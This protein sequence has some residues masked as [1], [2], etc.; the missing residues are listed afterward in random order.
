MPTGVINATSVN[1]R[2]PDGSIVT[3]LPEGTTVDIQLDDASTGQLLVT[4]VIAGQTR[5]GLVDKRYVTVG[6]PAPAPSSQAGGPLGNLIAK[7]EGN[8]MSYNRG[9]PGDAGARTIDFSQISLAEIQRRQFLPKTDPSSLFAVGK[10]QLIPVTLRLGIQALNVDTSESFG[11]ATQETIFRRYLVAIKRP[12]VKDYITGGP[13]SLAA[14]QLALAEEFASVADPSTGKSFYPPNNVAR[15]TPAAVAT[16]LDQEKQLYQTRLP[17][18]ASPDAAWISLSDPMG[19]SP[20]P[21]AAAPKISLAVGDSLAV[22]Q[23]MV[24]TPRLVALSADGR[25]TSFNNAMVAETGAGP[26]K[27]LQNIRTCV[28]GNASAFKGLTVSLSCGASNAPADVNVLADQI[29]ALENGGAV[30]V[31]I[32]VSNNGVFPGSQMTG[33]ELNAAIQKIATDNHVAFSGGFTGASAPDFIHPDMNGYRG[34]VASAAAAL[35]TA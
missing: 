19:A 29:T 31:V 8:Y 12:A 20:S 5:F 22:G 25:T 3:F 15:T 14:A 32:G 23:D 30:V 13:S 6:S 11:P 34:I 10:Y 35:A 21:A 24:I 4:A 27:I 1:L 7:F 9:L 16:A 33:V 17:S 26:A 18:A 2:G 28:A